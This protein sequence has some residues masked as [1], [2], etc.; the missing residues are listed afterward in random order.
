MTRND[1]AKHVHADNSAAAAR[2]ALAQRHSEFEK[3]FLA[4]H[5]GGHARQQQRGLCELRRGC[6]KHLR[7]GLDAAGRHATTTTQT[8]RFSVT[9]A[10]DGT[11]ISARIIDA[12]GRRQRGRFGATHAGARHVHRAVSRRRDGKERTYTINFNPQS[13]TN[14]RMKKYRSTS[15]KFACRFCLPLA[16]ARFRVRPE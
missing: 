12:V 16:A 8:S 3:Q 9:I 5:D 7:A 1:A 2:A 13:Q 4:Q 10:S 11:V 14:A 15:S 6:Q